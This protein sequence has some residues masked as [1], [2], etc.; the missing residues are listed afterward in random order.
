MKTF[1]WVVWALVLGYVYGHSK[2]WQEAHVMVDTECSLTGS[3]FVGPQA[4]VC[5]KK[6]AP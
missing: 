3:F 5:A 1:L 4:F 2:G 6:E